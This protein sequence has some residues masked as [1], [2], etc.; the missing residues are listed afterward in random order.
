M[1]YEFHPEAQAEFWDAAQ[2]MNPKN[3]AW[4]CASRAK[5]PMLLDKSWAIL[6]FGGNAAEVTVASTARSFPIT[7]LISYGM[8]RW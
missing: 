1:T 7:S 6:I 8:R 3:P 5:W 2:R 4:G